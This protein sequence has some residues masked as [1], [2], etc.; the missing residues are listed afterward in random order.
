MIRSA[1]FIALCTFVL[2]SGLSFGRIGRTTWEDR[3]NAIEVANG[4]SIVRTAD[5]FNVTDSRGRYRF[6][7]AQNSSSSS[8]KK[9]DSGWQT[10]LWAY[11]SEF[12]YFSANWFV[13]PTPSYDED[14]VLFFF[15]SL[16]NSATNEIL[17]PVLQY[18]N[19]ISGWSLASWY[20]GPAG[21]FHSSAVAVNPGDSILGFIFLDGST[22]YI[23]GYANSNLIAWITVSDST[24]SL[25]EPY[26]QLTLEVYGVNYCSDY[27]PSNYITFDNVEISNDGTLVSPYWY[28]DIY[29][30]DCGQSATNTPVPTLKWDSFA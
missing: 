14:Q 24:I 8:S 19:I 23:L 21:Y 2:F 9:R 15:N 22:W 30:S 12:T 5:G 16:E 10:A 20:G 17:Q 4:T 11:G 18:N 13:P 6:Y 29:E 27:P 28:S 1:L 7:P 25:I 3:K 26:A